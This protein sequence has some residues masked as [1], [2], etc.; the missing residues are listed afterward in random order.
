MNRNFAARNLHRDPSIQQI[1]HDLTLDSHRARLL[2]RLLLTRQRHFVGGDREILL[3]GLSTAVSASEVAAA[4]AATTTASTEAGGPKLT[5]PP[6]PPPF[7]IEVLL[8]QAREKIIHSEAA[9]NG[10]ITCSSSNQHVKQ[11]EVPSVADV[12][13]VVEVVIP[14]NGES[15]VETEAVDAMSSEVVGTKPPLAAAA[16]AALPASVVPHPARQMAPLSAIISLEVS[17]VSEE[18]TSNGGGHTTTSILAA[19]ASTEAT[20]IED[21]DASGAA[22]LQQQKKQEYQDEQEQKAAEGLTG[23][24]SWLAVAENEAVGGDALKELEAAAAASMIP[25]GTT[26]HQHPSYHPSTKSVEEATPKLHHHHHHHHHYHHHQHTL[27][28][29]QQCQKLSIL[30]FFTGKN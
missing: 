26:N 13:N 2:E 19:S 18:A 9:N 5:Q 12:V 16:V 15:L 8:Q 23:K 24:D 20:T 29:Q 27:R 22:K 3:S 1:T 28:S 7:N 21:E 25:S 30:V 4:A 17:N 10:S 11:P 14:E 6:A